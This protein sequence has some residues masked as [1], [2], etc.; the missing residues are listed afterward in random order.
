MLEA[1]CKEL[2]CPQ[3]LPSGGTGVV[4]SLSEQRGGELRVTAL[5]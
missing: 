1:L 3:G 4:P 2:C 5:F